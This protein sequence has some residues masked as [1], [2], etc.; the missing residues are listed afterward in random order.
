MLCGTAICGN[1]F[2]RVTRAAFIGGGRDCVVANNLFVDCEPALHIDARALNWA[3]Y[4]VDTTM[5]ER[6]EAMPYRAPHW[7]AK[8]PELVELWEDE[9][10]APKGNTIERNVCQ[11]G[12]WDGVRDDARPY[13]TLGEN[14]VADDV[15]LLGQPPQ[16]FRLRDDSPAHAMGFE[17]IPVEEIGLCRDRAAE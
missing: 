1:L 5:K 9:P 4:H 6:L 7:V 11:G 17:T 3:S 2:Y 8:Y 13:L 12:T 10:G 15:G 14:L 16:E